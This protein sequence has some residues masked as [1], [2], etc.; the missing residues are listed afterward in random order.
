MKDL[1]K[2]YDFSDNTQYYDMIAE[3]M[4]NGQKQQAIE[5]Y[6][7]MPQQHKREFITLLINGDYDYAISPAQIHDFIWAND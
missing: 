6:L 2:Q 7:A 5:Q 3:S 1:L 4:L